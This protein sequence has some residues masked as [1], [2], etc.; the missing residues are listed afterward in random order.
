MN[1][2]PSRSRSG[3]R[4][5]GHASRWCSLLADAR[6]A[7]CSGSITDGSN[8]NCNMTVSFK[9]PKQRIENAVGKRE[10]SHEHLCSAN[11][12]RPALQLENNGGLLASVNR[13]RVAIRRHPPLWIS[14]RV[15]PA[16][17]LSPLRAREEAPASRVGPRVK[18][19]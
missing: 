4:A 16:S 12:M 19:Y 15:E 13:S 14:D 1:R 11:P 5:S 6:H 10:I 2:V 17:A 7:D 3:Q 18:E 9:T 8:L